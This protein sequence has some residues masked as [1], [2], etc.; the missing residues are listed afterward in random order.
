MAVTPPTPGETVNS[1]A[2]TAAAAAT[3]APAIE[4]LDDAF[5]SMWA[6][7]SDKGEML[8]TITSALGSL[9]VANSLYSNQLYKDTVMGME[10]AARVP[11]TIAAEIAGGNILAGT[12]LNEQAKIL[13]EDA[14]RTVSPTRKGDCVP[15]L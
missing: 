6:G 11:R 5:K 15:L 12:A 4:Q 2:S 10:A 14:T 3:A 1:I 13:F 8:G 7:L 9:V